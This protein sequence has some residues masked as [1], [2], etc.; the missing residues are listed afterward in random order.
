MQPHFQ[1]DDMDFDPQVRLELVGSEMTLEEAL[2]DEDNVLQ[3]LEY[4]QQR[5]D[6]CTHLL[7][8]RE[9]LTAIV[10]T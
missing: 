5:L 1:S 9:T 3:E 7:E 4:P 6:L 10:A 2:D 8:H